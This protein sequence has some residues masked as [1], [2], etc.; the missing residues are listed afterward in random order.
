MEEVKNIHQKGF[1]RVLIALVLVMV[2]VFLGARTLREVRESRAI[3]PENTISISGEG[4]VFAKPDV[5]EITITIFK[6]AQDPE[7]VTRLASVASDDVVNF[8]NDK[9]IKE[10]D[11]KTIGYSLS[12]RYDYTRSN[13]QVLKGWQVR[14]SLRVKIRHLDDSGDII[15]GA[16]ENGAHEISSLSFTIDEP[17]TL[18]REAREEAIKDAREKAEAL[19]SDLGVRLGRIVGFSEGGRGGI[20]YAEKSYATLDSV[21][22]NAIPSPSI[23]VGENEITSNVTIIFE[24][25]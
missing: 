3:V 23:P 20:Y 4:S 24:L 13:G 11:I 15:A 18:E 7:V 6:E 8:L 16:T 12:P 2:V 21:G 1:L 25:K 10:E 19:A 9:G 5:G 14:Q 17:D 22:G